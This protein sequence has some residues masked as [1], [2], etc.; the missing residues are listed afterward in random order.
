M[1]GIYA[2]GN[3][4]GAH[5]NPAVSFAFGLI[6]AMD[7]KTVGL[8]SVAQVFGGL[9]AAL[10]YEFLFWN[11]FNL[12]PAKYANYVDVGLCEVVYTCMLV[13]VVLNVAVSHNLAGKNSF[14]GLAIGFVIIAGAYGA[15]PISGGCFNPAV[16]IGI[17]TA[18]VLQG[19]GWC[20]AYTFYELVG[21]AIAVVLFMLV[22]P[23][24]FGRSNTE[25][26]VLVSEFSG[27]FMLVFTVG[28]NIL[29]GSPSGAY[30]IAAS[31]MCM[32]YALG[33]VS[34]AHFNPAVTFAVL[35]CGTDARLTGVRAAKYAVV[36]F[37]GGVVGAW[38]FMFL[39]LRQF[40]KTVDKG[41]I[42]NALSPEKDSWVK[43][44]FAETMFTFLLCYVVVTVA[45]S[46]SSNKTMFGL[47]IGTCIT[48]GGNAIGSISG[49]SLNPAVSTGL[50][51][52]CEMAGNQSRILGLF[53]YILFEL[54]GGALAALCFT[55]T[56]ISSDKDAELTVGS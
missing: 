56:H 39:A 42:F 48:V 19:W 47:A 26:A 40:G 12:Q 23:E 37:I 17:D 27:T 1:V 10:T 38:T 54:V 35:L 20:L 4:S 44:L 15:G 8:Y 21:A 6:G 16:A 32:I 2:L 50:H 46:T 33:D 51:T 43:I 30:S 5:F 18:S 31:L 13:F 52:A 11:S 22:R 49:G 29:A 53:L 7:W 28:M 24:D 34:G 25:L 14:Y 9:M 36:Q 41:D 55:A 3:I 45:T